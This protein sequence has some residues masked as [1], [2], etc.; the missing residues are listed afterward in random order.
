MSP[1]FP[2]GSVA[3]LRIVQPSDHRNGIQQRLS[4]LGCEF[5]YRR[6]QPVT[7]G[8]ADLFPRLTPLR[9]KNKEELAPICRMLPSFDKS[10][11]FHRSDRASHRLGL[12]CLGTGKVR[13]CHWPGF[14]QPG[15]D[16]HLRPCQFALVGD[17]S[18]ASRQLASDQQQL[19]NGGLEFSR[20]VHAGHNIY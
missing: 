17:G 12:Y 10:F 6:Q 19:R 3:C 9:S 1:S 20:D 15:H 5:A 16:C 13:Y 14:F 8:E 7:F 11:F 2:S 18:Q 4:F